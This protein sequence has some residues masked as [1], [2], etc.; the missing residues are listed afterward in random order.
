MPRLNLFLW[1]IIIKFEI[2]REKMLCA[3]DWDESKTKKDLCVFVPV[4]LLIAIF[5][6]SAG[7]FPSSILLRKTNDEPNRR[8][9]CS[10]HRANRHICCSEDLNDIFI[11]LHHT[12]VFGRRIERKKFNFID[13]NSIDIVKRHKPSKQQHHLHSNRSQWW[14]KRFMELWW[15]RQWRCVRDVDRIARYLC[16]FAT[17]R[18]IIW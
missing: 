9:W 5:G 16:A 8:L 2:K 1:I 14:W 10:M 11:V 4:L 18:F 6:L 7:S 13:F 12:D 15:I 17:D 3:H